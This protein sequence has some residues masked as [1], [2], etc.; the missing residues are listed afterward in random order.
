VIRRDHT[1][2]HRDGGWVLRGGSCVDHGAVPLVMVWPR[3]SIV[4]GWCTDIGC[5]I[6]GINNFRNTV[7]AR[8]YLE[9]A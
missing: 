8:A 4:I 2:V 7:G 1:H 5:N 9:M 3:Y 6:D